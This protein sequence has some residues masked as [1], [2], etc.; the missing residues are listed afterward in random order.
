MSHGLLEKDSMFS[1]KEKPW[2]GLGTILAEAPSIEEG[3]KKAGLNWTVSLRPIVS[4]DN[5]RISVGTHKIVVR[6]DFNLPLG[7]VGSDYHILQN[8]EAFNFFDTFIENDLASLETAGSLFNGK[9]VFILAK[10]NQE[11]MHV[12]DDDVV[13]KYILLSNAHDGSQS[14]R[15]GYTPIRVVCNNTLSCAVHC[16]NSNLIKITHKTDV[17]ETL[18]T[19][20]ETMNIINQEFLATEE[21]YKELAKKGVDSNSLEKYVRQVFSTKKLE[22]IITD[23]EKEIEEDSRRKIIARVEEVFDSEPKHNMWT[24]YN[25]VNYY[26]NHDRGKSLENRYNSIW[27]GD[28]KRL[29]NRALQLAISL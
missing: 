5:D 12:T 15:I 28:S 7:V 2:H 25:S 17:V 8:Q 6:D 9:K 29:D 26:L 27:F 22:A 3:I 1:V 14:V 23:Y 24:L 11:D 16:K 18:E 19:V 20:K 4:D 13:E 10:I 21:Q